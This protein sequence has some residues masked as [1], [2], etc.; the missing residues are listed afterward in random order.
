MMEP[1]LSSN[2]DIETK[3][4]TIDIGALTYLMTKDDFEGWKKILA[5]NPQYREFVI[6]LPD[7]F[8]DVN[9]IKQIRFGMES[10]LSL[11]E[12]SVYADPCFSSK[13]MDILRQAFLTGLTIEQVKFFAIPSIASDNMSLFV[14]AFKLKPKLNDWQ[15]KEL[16]TH[17]DKMQYSRFYEMVDR[18]NRTNQQKLLSELLSPK[19]DEIKVI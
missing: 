10:E 15:L 2:I 14:N 9:K 18:F 5:S 11:E 6:N 3:N 16:L 8:Q 12:L 13:Q 7:S 19:V 17:A 4:E 1:L